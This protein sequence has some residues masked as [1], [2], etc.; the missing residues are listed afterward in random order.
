MGY[1]NRLKITGFRA[2]WHQLASRL[3]AQPTV[4]V[5]TIK[6]PDSA[7]G[8]GLGVLVALFPDPASHRYVAM[9]LPEGGDARWFLKPRGGDVASPDV[10]EAVYVCLGEAGPMFGHL[11]G[12]GSF[13]A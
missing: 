9:G 4:R 6:G 3:S 12:L 13:L 10:I 7:A 5:G 2:T 11:Y 8:P 1:T